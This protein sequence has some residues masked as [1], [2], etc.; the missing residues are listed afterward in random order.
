MINGYVTALCVCITD[1][2]TV[3]SVSCFK[4]IFK[5]DV[6]ISTQSQVNFIMTFLYIS[7]IIFCVAAHPFSQ[8]TLCCDPWPSSPGSH[9]CPNSSHFSFKLDV[10]YCP[11]FFC[12]PPLNVFFFSN[13]SFST[14]PCPPKRERDLNL[15]I[16]HERKNSICLPT[17]DFFHLT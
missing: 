8:W 4:F 6:K 13:D 16:A 1:T 2:H 9:P 17:S 3:V 5:I 14:P 11:F 10:F 15:E 12:F 7:V